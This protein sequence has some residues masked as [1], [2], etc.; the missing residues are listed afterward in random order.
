MPMLNY[1]IAGNAAGPRLLLLHAM[2]ADLHF[3]DEC[4]PLWQSTYRCIACDLRSA[5]QSP[6]STAPV[7]IDDHVHDLVALL[8]KTNTKSAVAIACAAST[9]VAAALAARHP[10][11]ISGLVLANA[12]PSLTPGGPGLRERAEVVRRT[13]IAAILPAAVERTFLEQPKDARY[14]RYLE[15][16]AAQDPEAYAWTLLGYADADV[17][18]E[19]PAVGCPALIIAGKH[20]VLLPPERAQSVHRAIPHSRYMLFEDAAH[21]LP[22]QAPETFAAAVH[23][24]VL[25]IRRD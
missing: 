7:T 13:G 3:W 5:G 10:T 20:D 8:D 12:T 15:R 6:T 4:V 21:F 25:G 11:R 14:R 24:F 9:T 2:G 17:E 23:E 19:L 1:V 18:K 22:Y 16:F